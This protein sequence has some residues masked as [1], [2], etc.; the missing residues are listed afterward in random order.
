M[1]TC[2]ERTPT[3][4]H[5]FLSEPAKEEPE[6]PKSEDTESKNARACFGLGLSQCP[7]QCSEISLL[8]RESEFGAGPPLV[9][10][11]PSSDPE[12][13]QAGEARAGAGHPAALS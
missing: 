1:T 11:P 10:L 8:G 4:C 7:S 5:L 3:P 6:A 2:R 9:C 12:S 13:L